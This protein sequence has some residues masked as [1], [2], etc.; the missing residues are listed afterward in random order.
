MSKR[1]KNPTLSKARK[2]SDY[3]LHMATGGSMGKE[4]EKKE[5]FEDKTDFADKRGLLDSLIKIATLESKEKA[6]DEPEST[7][8]RIRSNAHGGQT[9]GHKGNIAGAAEAG[10]EDHDEE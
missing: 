10:S 2:Y 8:D 7:F 6:E 5:G 3:L 9:D 4:F 1:S